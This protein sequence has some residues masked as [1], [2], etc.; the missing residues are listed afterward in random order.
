MLLLSIQAQTRSSYA[1]PRPFLGGALHG[2]FEHLIKEHAP[3]LMSALAPEGK[4][5]LKQYAI[6]PPAYEEKRH[7]QADFLSF[8]LIL[9][10][11]ASQHAHEVAEAILHW[12]ILKTHES[13]DHITNINVYL[14]KPGHEP[15]PLATSANKQIILQDLTFDWPNA[16]VFP[17][18]NKITVEWI[19][20]A[21]LINGQQKQN[22]TENSVPHIFKLVS[23]AYR[24][25]SDLEPTLALKL[26]FESAAWNDALWRI[27]A[28]T[29][30]PHNW[31]PVY[32]QYGSSTKQ[33]PF[34]MKGMMGSI[35]YKADEIP[36]IILET[37]HWGMWFGLG[38]KTT[39]GHGFYTI[40]TH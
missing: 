35:D 10:G 39:I 14:V 9:F 34:K 16:P 5:S 32:W 23:S 12:K 31:R 27:H 21:T 24:R 6:I 26:G 20:P 2:V 13:E 36:T 37:L 7:D 25:I 15:M 17:P 4:N 33:R 8:G 22:N 29:T 19:T 11:K 30:Q 28:V 18:T 3:Q 40:Q 1:F 38:Q